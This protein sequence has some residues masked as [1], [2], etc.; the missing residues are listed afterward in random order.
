MTSFIMCML[1]ISSLLANFIYYAPKG[2]EGFASFIEIPYV[3][4]SLI[5]FFVFGLMY[6]KREIEVM[7]DDY[8]SSEFKNEWLKRILSNGIF[9][10][11][12]TGVI[13]C[14]V[15]LKHYDPVLAPFLM[16]K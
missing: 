2:Q 7:I 1:S 14:A 5:S 10:L 11:G 12:V 3:N 13:S 15:I 9:L 4:F 6:L 8:V 16:K